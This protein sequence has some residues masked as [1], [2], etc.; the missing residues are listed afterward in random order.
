MK[1]KKII[2]NISF[3]AVKGPKD[4]EISGI[5]N[6][7]RVVAPNNL[8]IA[9]KGLKTDGSKFIAD[10]ISAGAI[11][12]VSDIFDPFLKNITQ[13]IHDNPQEIEADIAKVYYEEP[14]NELFTVGITGTNGKTTSTY[15]IKHVLDSLEKKCG[16][17]GTIEYILGN[18]NRY[19]SSRTT[20][21]CISVHKFFKEMIKT[22]SKAVVMEVSSHGLEQNRLKNIGFDVAIFSNLTLDHLDYHKTMEN[23]LA[24]KKKLFFLLKDNAKHAVV[25][26]DDPA[27]CKI[28]ENLPSKILTYSIKQKADLY[29]DNITFSL[30]GTQFLVHYKEQM[31]LFSTKL[32]GEYNVYN[33]LVA[34]AT[35]LINGGSLKDLSFII[36]SFQTVAGR[37]ERVVNNKELNI[38]IDYAHTDEALKNVLTTLQKIKKGKIITVFGCGGDRDKSKRAKMGKVCEELSDF[39]IVTSDNPRSEN[40]QSIINEILLGFSLKN[41][42]LVEID[43]KKSIETAILMASTKDIVLIA[44]K[45][46]EKYQIIGNQSYPFDDYKVAKEICERI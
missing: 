12:I 3:K 10:A 26:I 41:R 15:L 28:L 40:P 13:L 30:D 23:Y 17:I 19:A 42:Y 39:C 25:N 33:V 18:N 8:F 27:S 11:C 43:R 2:K 29:A 20:P 24:A 37:L 6:D 34:I 46:H 1:L 36:P 35:G 38:F 4:I 21:D 16:L 22:G 32:V 7:S 45:G 44:G 14:S 5:A 9:K 31:E